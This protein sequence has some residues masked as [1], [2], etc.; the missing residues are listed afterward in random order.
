MEKYNF[1]YYEDLFGE[2]AGSKIPVNVLA[3]SYRN[4]QL[5]DPGK[6]YLTLTYNDGMTTTA[7]WEVLQLADC[8]KAKNV[9]FFVGASASP[10]LQQV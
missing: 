1:T 6:Y 3:K 9:I 2:E 10:L 8:K 7:V 5:H 4:L